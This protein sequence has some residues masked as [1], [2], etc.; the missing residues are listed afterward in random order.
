MRSRIAQRVVADRFERANE[1][2]EGR[3]R[4]VLSFSSDRAAAINIPDLNR[5]PVMEATHDLQDEDGNF[6]FYIGYSDVDG[7]DIIP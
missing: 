5:L 4:S 2:A 1:R 3:V 6:Y 7:P